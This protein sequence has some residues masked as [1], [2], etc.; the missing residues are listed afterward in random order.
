MSTMLRIAAWRRAFQI[1]SAIFSLLF[2]TVLIASTIR[3]YLEIH[4][5]EIA[6]QNCDQIPILT[7]LPFLIIPGLIGGAVLALRR[8]TSW[9][10]VVVWALMVLVPLGALIY[11]LVPSVRHAW[12]LPPTSV[13]AVFQSGFWN[14]ELLPYLMCVAGLVLALLGLLPAHEEIRQE[15]PAPR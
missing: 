4:S 2:A 6:P 13:T 15:E 1:A 3:I 8:Q 11:F 7:P 12:G 5:C 9:L 10:L 14:P